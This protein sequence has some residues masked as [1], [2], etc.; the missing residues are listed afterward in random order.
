MADKLS[1]LVSQSKQLTAHLTRPELP[2]IH[3]GLD[4]IEQQT[5]RLVPTQSIQDTSK[6]N[7]LLAQA[8]INAP[9]LSSQIA[10][11][12]PAQT[13]APL[14]PIHD[15]DISSY[16]RHSHEQSLIS[17]IEEGRRETENEFY[18]VLE[19]RVRKDW[20]NRK[21]RIFEEIGLSVAPVG[22]ERAG[23]D[24][25][26][27]GKSRLGPLSA[28]RSAGR[29]LGSSI[30][31]QPKQSM[32][33]HSKMM[34]YDRVIVQLN[35]ARLAHTSNPLI[36]NLIEAA[37]STTQTSTRPTSEQFVQLLQILA[38]ITNEQPPLPPSHAQAHLL[39]NTHVLERAY[40]KAYLGDPNSPAAVELRKKIVDGSRR[41]LEAQYWDI[42]ERIIQSKP[43]DA[44]LGGDPSLANKVRG[45]LSVRFYKGGRWEERLEIVS[46]KPLW[47]QMFYLVRTGNIREALQVAQEFEKPLNDREQNFV[48]FFQAWVESNDRVLPR[49]LQERVTNAYNSRIAF[50]P[51]A[52]PFKVALFKLMAKIEPHKK[53]LPIVTATTEDWVWFQLAMVDEHDGVGLR[54]LGDV[55]ESYGEK[56]FGVDPSAGSP[57]AASVGLGASVAPLGA[58]TSSGGSAATK[59]AL[60]ARL[61]LICGLFEKAVAALYQHP[62]LQVEA[63]HLAIALAYYG[64][65]RV[66]SREEMSEVD[67]LIT[68]PTDPTVLNFPLLISRY[69]RQF[70]KSDPKE[71]LQ[72]AY[73]V[74]LSS[75]TRPST[76]SRFGSTAAASSGGDEHLDIAREFVRRIIIG[77][78]GKWDELVGGFREDLSRFQGVIERD[79]PLL[80]INTIA[81]YQE[82]ILKKAAS[83]CE[84]NR[85]SVDAIRLYHLAGAN[86]TVMSCLARALGELLS[87]PNGGGDEGKQLEALATDV[88]KYQEGRG[89]KTRDADDV[90]K[91][92]W[93]RTARESHAQGDLDKALDA[94]EQSNLVPMDGDI[95][96]T[97]RKMD[98]FRAMDPAITR[99]LGEILELS[100]TILKDLH[101]RIKN[102]TSGEPD[103]QARLAKIRKRARAVMTFAGMQKYSLSSETYGKLTTMEVQMAH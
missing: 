54:E 49:Q 51:N 64:L 12:N 37:K 22:E 38:L 9:I 72:Y 103:R 69:I 79:L 43:V 39:N 93:I 18:R 2:S 58:S 5:K 46:G 63:V 30:P 41:A 14:Q 50:G 73:C 92:I 90:I 89:E 36:F 34:A 21:K 40:A 31:P 56:H 44:A 3:L 17:A 16:L 102:S 82:I 95:Q 27:F 60:W 10:S 6:G 80:K 35:A 86:D 91:L 83:H 81:E 7:Y 85:R 11:L 59:K 53:S 61:L 67:V 28:S 100:M 75:D 23:G 94:I 77:T 13:F 62:E 65:L 99:N 29:P 19:E 70:Q 76:T 24:I 20:E 55:L 45:Y 33:M 4:Q 32:S 88:L 57:A 78:E 71:A 42:I 25:N 66:P 87:E 98:E 68:S 96:S 74:A 47:A 8:H 48:A 1:S 52:D 101:I 15:T 97:S 26:A 84:Q